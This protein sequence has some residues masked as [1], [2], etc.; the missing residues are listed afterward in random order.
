MMSKIYD[1]DNNDDDGDND[2]YDDD[3]FIPL[4]SGITKNTIVID[5]IIAA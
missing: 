5:T 2:D 4:I 3:V 1:D